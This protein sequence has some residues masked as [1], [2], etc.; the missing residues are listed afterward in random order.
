MPAL[1]RV[2][3]SRVLSRL[4]WPSTFWRIWSGD[5][6][7]L[8]NLPFERSGASSFPIGPLQFGHFGAPTVKPVIFSLRHSSHLQTVFLPPNFPLFAT[9][10]PSASTMSK[11][12]SMLGALLTEVPTPN[13]STPARD[14]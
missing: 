11:A 7:I 4:S 9:G 3:S 14:S 12:K 5:G 8:D 1:A 10:F 13:P 6:S 2:H